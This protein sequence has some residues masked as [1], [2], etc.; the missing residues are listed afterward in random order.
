MKECNKCHIVKEF[1]C[2]SKK[3]EGLQPICKECDADRRRLYVATYPEKVKESSKRTRLKHGKKYYLNSRDKDLKRS[4]EYKKNNKEKVR[5][6]Y[7]IWQ[8]KN[9]AKQTAY[10]NS[11]RASKLQATPPWL[12]DEQKEE[13][14]E[15]YRIRKHMS[16]FHEEIY[17]VDHIEPLKGK[18]SCGLHVPWNLQVIPASEN[19]RKHRKMPD[20]FYGKASGEAQEFY[21]TSV[22]GSDIYVR[23]AICTV[24]FTTI[25][26]INK[27][28]RPIRSKSSTPNKKAPILSGNIKMDK[29]KVGGRN[30]NNPIRY[31]W[32]VTKITK[33]YKKR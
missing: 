2:F 4:R 16:E 32:T 23:N 7:R 5:N 18:N 28:M 8:Q 13:I 10:E 20:E 27:K 33:K 30:S 24:Y 17:H 15:F 6:D 29:A 21:Q 1:S 25:N 12:T 22:N 11:R 14:V 31:G 19:V 9:R 26:N 3:L